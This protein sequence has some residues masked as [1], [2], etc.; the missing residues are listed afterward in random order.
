MDYVKIILLLIG[1]ILLTGCG[2]PDVHSTT[3][4]VVH[5]GGPETVPVVE[6][7]APEQPDLNC[8]QSDLT[9]ARSAVASEWDLSGPYD[10]LETQLAYIKASLR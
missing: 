7:C 9:Q 8:I 4:R 3:V 6:I 2:K 1:A 10:G 5:N